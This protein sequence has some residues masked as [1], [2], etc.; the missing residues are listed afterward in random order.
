MQA[1]SSDLGQAL[2]FLRQWPAAFPHLTAIH[3]DAAGEK[4]LV[5]ARAF[6]HGDLESGA[7]ERWLR[8]RDGVANL[9]FTVNSLIAPED[10][11][12]S[13]ANVREAVALHLDVDLPEGVEQPAGI[14]AMLER[15]SAFKH[16]PSLVV[17]SGGGLQFFWVL[18]PSSRVQ[19]DGDPARVEAAEA[20]NRAMEDEATTVFEGMAKVDHCFNLD[21]IMRLPGTVNVPDAKKRARGRVRALATVVASTGCVYPLSAFGA[22]GPSTTGAS[23]PA[24]RGERAVVNIAWEEARA[25]HAA[26][27]L[28]LDALR[29]RGVDEETCIALQHG[30]NLRSLHE[31]HAAR[32]HRVAAGPYGSFSEVTL[33]VARGLLR[34][35]LTNE[36]IA[37]VLGNA[38]HA[39]NRHVTKQKDDKTRQRAITRVVAKVRAD[40]AGSLRR[41]AASAAGVPE[42][43][44]CWDDYGV[45]PKPTMRNAVIAVDALGV[46]CSL[47]L[48]KNRVAIQYQGQAADVQTLIGEVTDHRLGALRSIVDKRWGI[49]LGAVNVHDAVMEIARDHAHDP[50][51]DY[52]TECEGKWDGQSRLDAWMIDHLGAEDTPLN[53]AIGRTALVAS[54]RRARVPGAKYDLI[55]V[56]EGPEGYGKS[57]LVAILY[58]REFFSDQHILGLED[59][60]VQEQVEGI[61]GYE[62]ADLTGM[63]RAD[64]EKVKAFASR[65]HDRAR[66][67]WGRVREEVA[68]RCVFWGTTNDDHYLLSQTGNRRFLPVLVTRRIDLD[69]LRAVR[70][71]LWGEA[72]RAEQETRGDINIPSSLWPAA[73]EAQEQRRIKDPWEDVALACPRFVT[74][75]DA[76]G[77]QQI[78]I[79]HFAPSAPDSSGADGDKPTERVQSSVVLEHVF[80]VPV[81]QQN[82]FHYKRLATVME[83]AGWQRTKVGT[84]RV[85]SGKVRGYWRPAQGDESA[86]APPQRGDDEQEQEIPF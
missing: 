30:D 55:A 10:K 80:R 24:A 5:E 25:L 14:A 16:E 77:R 18:E 84:L 23:A 1:P 76:D 35:G 60:Q 29:A 27:S 85:G 34:A 82:Q 11:K 53:R 42:W 21:R 74:V 49:D 78:R 8:E 3:V 63:N 86:Y 45:D 52:L 33:A 19:V 40:G 44:D 43:R 68:R 72:A 62:C 22:A 28:T 61:W 48:F 54:V 41:Q 39:G 75:R 50:V 69:A 83:L 9:Y 65:T 38:G 12:A 26:G 79:I 81:G 15:V 70:D 32:G 66:R 6:T 46:R 47:D 56:L 73:A 51:L 71:Q 13:K 57:S 59:R 20:Y 37:A 64:V 36:E 7:V 58:G 17:N 2:E 4:G 31:A 67:A